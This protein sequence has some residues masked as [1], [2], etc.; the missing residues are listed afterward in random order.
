MTAM[1]ISLPEELKEYV[2]QQTKSGYSTPSEYVRELIR[3]DRKRRARERLD[4][5]LL[6]GLDSGD[7]IPATPEFWST[8]KREALAKL[9]PRKPS[10]K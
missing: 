3:E 8:L 10:K 4:L 9:K 5:L 7:P 6:E 1:N 2:E